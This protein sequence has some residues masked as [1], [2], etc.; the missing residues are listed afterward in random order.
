[1][2]PFIAVTASNSLSQVNGEHVGVDSTGNVYLAGSFKGQVD[3][4]PSASIDTRLNTSHDAFLVKLSSSGSLGWHQTLAGSEAL[5]DMVVTSNSVIIGGHFRT[6]F[7]LPGMAPVAPNGTPTT[8]GFYSRDIYFAEFSFNGA[9]QWTA[10]IGGEKTEL[11]SSFDLAA[12][13]SLVV[14]GTYWGTS[15]DFDNDPLT[16]PELIGR[17]STSSSPKFLVRLRRS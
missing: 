6:P 12:D 13:G 1:V 2:A 14:V 4:N 17:T 7:T 5:M 10:I 9:L 8:S 3:I 15:L 11:L 16:P